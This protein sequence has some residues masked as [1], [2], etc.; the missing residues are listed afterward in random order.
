MQPF[1]S[2]TRASIIS[3]PHTIC[4]CSSAFSSSSG[5]LLHGIYC[6]AAGLAV[7]F[8]T[9]RPARDGG[10]SLRVLVFDFRFVFFLAISL[11]ALVLRGASQPCHANMWAGSRAQP[12]VISP[13]V[14][15]INCGHLA[16][17]TRTAQLLWNQRGNHE[18]E[19]ALSGHCCGTRRGGPGEKKRP[20]FHPHLPDVHLRSHRQR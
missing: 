17:P 19:R 20:C 3:W 2:S 13:E 15:I 9:A 7:R 1:F 16:C 18:T 5:T 4:R 12:S 14:G 8:H 11:S 10:L 6:S